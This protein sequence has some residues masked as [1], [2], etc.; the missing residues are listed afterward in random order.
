[1][2]TTGLRKSPS[3][4]PSASVR[5]RGEGP[6]PA[7]PAGTDFVLRRRARDQARSSACDRHYSSGRCVC[8]GEEKASDSRCI[9][10]DGRR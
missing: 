7:A 2:S 10:Q 5:S 4:L 6:L 3:A 9:L 8:N 1:M